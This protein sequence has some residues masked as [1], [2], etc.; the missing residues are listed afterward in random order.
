MLSLN[1]RQTSFRRFLTKPGFFNLTSTFRSDSDFPIPYMKTI[2]REEHCIS[3]LPNSTIIKQKDKFISWL[4]SNCRS[5]SKREE[6]YA[7]LSRYI[8]T[9]KLGKCGKRTPCKRMSPSCTNEI[10]KKSK[11]YF[12]AENSICKDYITGKMF[13]I[14]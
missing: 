5:S 12:S 3:C 7:K 4:V 6:Y 10:I 13:E 2:Q 1:F 11:F 8:P 14:L 9:Q